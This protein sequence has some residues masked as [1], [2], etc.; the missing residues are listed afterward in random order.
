MKHIIHLLV[1]C[2]LVAS[3]ARPSSKVV[4]DGEVE[5]FDDLENVIVDLLH[6][7]GEF[8]K[9][10][11]SD[12]LRD[13]RFHLETDSLPDGSNAYFSLLMYSD[14]FSTLNYGPE[15]YLEPGA[16]INIKGQ[17]RHY[18]TAEITSPVKDQKLRQRLVKKMSQADLG[19]FQELQAEYDCGIH[20]YY[21]DAN[22][23]DWQKESLRMHCISVKAQA[24]S[25]SDILYRQRLELMKSEPVGRYWMKW[26]DNYAKMVV[27]K[28]HP[29]YRPEVESLFAGLSPEMKQ[30]PEGQE[31]ESF[32]FPMKEVKIGEVMPKYEYVD[33]EG[34]GRSISEFRGKKV[35]L[36]FWGNGCGPCRQSIP[37][38]QRLHDH[39]GDRLAIISISI[40]SER[41]WKKSEKEHPMT[42]ENWR[43]PSGYSGSIRIFGSHEFP[44]FVLISPEGKVMK[45]IKG[46]NEEDLKELIDSDEK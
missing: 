13:G 10:F 26:L 1:L 19:D 42:W 16:H 21:Y 45:I 20:R 35:L 7:D 40:D 25:I 17:G 24:D 28:M 15:L 38:I 3:C 11:L 44:T 2:A 8:G 43:D 32:L 34:K 33:H 36:D 31:I 29:E 14:R 27:Y 39:Y 37:G 12:T 4:I 5:G 18:Y 6:F 41:V 22:L 9:R 30:S 23:T 46:F